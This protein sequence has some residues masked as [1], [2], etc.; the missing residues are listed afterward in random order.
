MQNSLSVAEFETLVSNL[1][2]D[3]CGLSFNPSTMQV[4]EL[5]NV[6]IKTKVNRQVHMKKIQ[7]KTTVQHNSHICETGSILTIDS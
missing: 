6:V 4:L 3:D 5:F 7:W 2:G 1:L